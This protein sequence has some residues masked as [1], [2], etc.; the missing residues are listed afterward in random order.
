M[1]NSFLHLLFYLLV[2]TFEFR[3]ETSTSLLEEIRQLTEFLPRYTEFLRRLFLPTWLFVAHLV[4]S[5]FYQ[6]MIGAFRNVGFF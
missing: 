2:T 1:S 4:L 6:G 5:Y 3:V